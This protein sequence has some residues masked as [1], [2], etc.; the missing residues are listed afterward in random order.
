MTEQEKQE[1][2]EKFDKIRDDTEFGELMFAA[3][4]PEAIVALFASRDI[5]V[6]LEDAQRG[7][8]ILHEPD[9]LLDEL[10]DRLNRSEDDAE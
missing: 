4:S 9:D 8:E 3:E 6:D 2:K 7:Y 5:V 10:E 1:R